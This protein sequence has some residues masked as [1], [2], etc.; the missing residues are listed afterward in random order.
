MNRTSSRR[1]TQAP[2]DQW[3][4]TVALA[5]S[6]LRVQHDEDDALIEHYIKFSLDYFERSSDTAVA[7]SHHRLQMD[8]WPFHGI[9]DLPNPP[10]R[11]VTSVT[12]KDADGNDVLVSVEDFKLSL[13]GGR[14]RVILARTLIGCKPYLPITVS[15]VAGYGTMTIPADKGQGYG[16]YSYGDT[17]YFGDAPTDQTESYDWPLTIV[18]AMLLMVG[19]CYENRETVVIG[20]ITKDLDHAFTALM[21]KHRVYGL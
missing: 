8:S 12:Y 15:Y 7:F 10:A 3:P 1:L 11:Q 20:T 17:A 13:N 16:A 5:K 9:I 6:H 19:H 4:C 14:G 18:Q 2:F 21:H